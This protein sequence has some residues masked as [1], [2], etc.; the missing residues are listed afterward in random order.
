ML[1]LAEVAVTFSRWIDLVIVCIPTAVPQI[2]SS[3]FKT[4]T[5]C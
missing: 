5:D 4:H 2:Y 1:Y 3:E